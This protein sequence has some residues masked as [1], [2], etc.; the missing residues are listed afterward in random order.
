MHCGVAKKKKKGLR[1]G[2][3]AAEAVPTHKLLELMPLET[4]RNKG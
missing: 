2:G 3:T 1:D 4:G